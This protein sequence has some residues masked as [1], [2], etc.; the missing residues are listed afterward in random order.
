MRE[1]VFQRYRKKA[2]I[3]SSSKRVGGWWIISEVA[4]K[5]NSSIF[6]G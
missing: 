2:V 3:F 1:E 4:T 6:S 5:E